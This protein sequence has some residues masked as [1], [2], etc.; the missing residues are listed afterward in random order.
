MH[1][2]SNLR[3]IHLA[4]DISFSCSWEGTYIYF[5][6]RYQSKVSVIFSDYVQTNGR[7]AGN[8]GNISLKGSCFIIF[9][10]TK[11]YLDIAENLICNVWTKLSHLTN[12]LRKFRILLNYIYCIGKCFEMSE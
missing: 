3:E 11:D 12:S 9:A 10:V 5:R 7:Y 1:F 6:L 4:M 2:Y 8:L